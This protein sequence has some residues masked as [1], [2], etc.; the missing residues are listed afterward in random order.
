MIA[1]FNLWSCPSAEGHIPTG[2]RRTRYTIRIAGI[3]ILS[4]SMVSSSIKHVVSVHRPFLAV[5]MHKMGPRN[6]RP[7]NLASRTCSGDDVLTTTFLSIVLVER[8]G[9]P[10]YTT[11]LLHYLLPK[12]GLLSYRLTN[13][14]K[15]LNT[16][17]NRLSGR[18]SRSSSNPRRRYHHKFG[19]VWLG[20]NIGP[21]RC[22]ELMNYYIAEAR[23]RGRTD[24]TISASRFSV[25]LSIHT[26]N[27]AFVDNL[28]D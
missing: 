15:E 1:H 4:T 3:V 9:Q 12:S 14:Q 25:Q 17:N 7:C 6:E 8:G 28:F 22:N 20:R 2:L 19:D 26:Y 21:S 24:L 23:S 18:D 13:E 16:S 10:R 5:L 27:Q 11:N